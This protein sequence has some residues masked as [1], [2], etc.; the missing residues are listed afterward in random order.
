MN[1]KQT[2]KLLAFLSTCFSDSDADTDEQTARDFAASSSPERQQEIIA[3][4]KRLLASEE[5]PLEE[6]GSEANRWF[7]EAS[8]GRQW[9]QRIVSILEAGQGSSSVVVK[10]SNGTPLAEGDTVMV[11]KDLKVKGGSSD[12]KRGTVIKK[13]HLIDDPDVIECRVDGSTL[14]LKTIFLK[15]A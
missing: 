4:A 11:I 7:A 14:V 8:E 12:L 1:L 3:D 6:I 15:K 13:V 5:F 10:D 2:P 9:L